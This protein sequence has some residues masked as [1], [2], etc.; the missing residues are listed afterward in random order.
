MSEPSAVPVS[1]LDLLPET[2]IFNWRWLF[3]RPL[4]NRSSFRSPLATKYPRSPR[5]QCPLMPSKARGSETGAISKNGVK[6][7]SAAQTD[8]SALPHQWRSE[9]HLTGAELCGGFT[10]PSK[11][12]APKSHNRSGKNSLRWAYKREIIKALKAPCGPNF[13]F[14]FGIK[15]IKNVCALI[16]P[17]EFYIAQCSVMLAKNCWLDLHAAARISLK[18]KTFTR[19][20]Q[21]RRFQRY[22]QPLYEFHYCEAHSCI[23]PFIDFL[24]FA[25]D[26]NPN[27]STTYRIRNLTKY[28]LAWSEFFRS[29]LHVKLYENCWKLLASLSSTI[30]SALAPS[31]QLQNIDPISWCNETFSSLSVGGEFSH[32][33]GKTTFPSFSDSVKIVI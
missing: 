33:P 8:I 12:N 21:S 19:R 17:S 13:S 15:F 6:C 11:Y 7:T 28:S 31:L 22:L 1:K 25:F 5:N 3:G 23:H 18:L 4:S 9:T 2:W 29:H 16:F 32:F 30:Q 14:A 10:L 27:I 24:M 26:C 20:Y